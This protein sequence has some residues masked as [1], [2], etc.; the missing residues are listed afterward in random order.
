M[1]LGPG[2]V[3]TPPF[4][5]GKLSIVGK[6]MFDVFAENRLDSDYYS[7]GAAWKF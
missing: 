1:G 6:A 7:F 2:I 3:W 4:A 5:R